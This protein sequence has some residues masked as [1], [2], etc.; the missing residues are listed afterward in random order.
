MNSPAEPVAP[1][2][3]HTAGPSGGKHV[4]A[5]PALKYKLKATKGE[6]TIEP[7]YHLSCDVIPWQPDKHCCHSH[8]HSDTCDPCCHGSSRHRERKSDRN[9][10]RRSVQKSRRE[11]ISDF[12]SDYE[13]YEQ[14]HMQRLEKE[15]KRDGGPRGQG[16]SQGH[17]G[18]KYEKP[19]RDKPRVHKGQ[20]RSYS[21]SAETDAESGVTL[22][23]EDLKLTRKKVTHVGR[24]NVKNSEVLSE[25]NSK[26]S[27][28]RQSDD[29]K[30]KSRR[31][32]GHEK[33]RHKNEK[34][35]KDRQDKQMD[36]VAPQRSRSPTKARDGQKEKVRKQRSTSPSKCDVLDIRGSR[37]GLGSTIG[38]VKFMSKSCNDKSD[39]VKLNQ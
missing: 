11:E 38:Q 30:G 2:E 14:K 19:E 25:S 39:S 3:I 18:G 16:H 23:M 8:H 17:G 22:S 1:S 35:S 31:V 7:H 33:D 32:K 13:I 15:L 36:K 28:E 37:V 21:D 29:D 12:D 10:Q 6:G 9:K 26:V 20:D 24:N 4:I 5:S 34:V 27:R